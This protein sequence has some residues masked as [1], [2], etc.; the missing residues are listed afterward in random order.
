MEPRYYVIFVLIFV[1]MQVLVFVATR[2]LFWLFG[3]KFRYQTRRWITVLGFLLPNLLILGNTLQVFALFRVVALIL[4][5]LLYASFVGIGV[6]LVRKLTYQRRNFGKIERLLRLAAPLAFF[7]LIGLSLYN[8]YTP[9]ISYYQLS[10]NKPMKPLRIGMASDLHL[11]K[12][13]GG[14]ELEQLA[15][16]FNEQKVDVIL[17]PG[18]IMDDD[19]VAYDAENMQP[20]FEKLR[21][22]LGVYATLGNHD[23]LGGKAVQADIVKAI[24]KAG[25]TLLQD[26]SVTI[27]NE[28]VLIGRHDDLDKN[29]PSTQSLL[30]GVDQNLPIIVLDHRPSEIE[31]HANLPI[32]L[33]VSGHTHKGQIFPANIITKLSYVLDYGYQEINGR[34]FVV[35]SGYGFWGV[36]MRLGSQSEVV[37]IDLKGN[38]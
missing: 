32:D 26:Q 25:I 19:T 33:Q 1:L 38:N 10:I 18:D 24:Q 8:A 23:I 28:L 3:D 22:P 12:L 4:V 11:G 15:K 16:I 20:H 14:K 17:L 13:F 6:W 30:N 37:I 21:A 36:P 9:S 35:S 7:G 2:T 29:R 34:H 31:L 5:I 27:N